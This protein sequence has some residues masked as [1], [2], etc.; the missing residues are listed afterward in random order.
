MLAG[1]DHPQAPRLA[2]ERGWAGGVAELPGELHLLLLELLKLLLTRPRALP[3][4][5]E[6]HE[7]IQIGDEH[8]EQDEHEDDPPDP[9]PANAAGPDTAL[10]PS[11]WRP[12]WRGICPAA[13]AYRFAVA[14]DFP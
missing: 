13:H 3:R 9:V 1:L 10:D 5:E 6:V 4:L 11:A 8:T 2:L 7:R 14:P 12:P